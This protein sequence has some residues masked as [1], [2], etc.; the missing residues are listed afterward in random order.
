LKELQEINKEHVVKAL[1]AKTGK[2][3]AKFGKA[4]GKDE[5]KEWRAWS[6][7]SEWEKEDA[8]KSLQVCLMGP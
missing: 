2:I 7:M 1:E 5:P 8:Y 4:R 3:H 6:K